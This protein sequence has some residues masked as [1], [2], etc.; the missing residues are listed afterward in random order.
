MHSEVNL[1]AFD[2][3]NSSTKRNSGEPAVLSAVVRK[4]KLKGMKI[5]IVVTFVIVMSL[6]LEATAWCAEPEWV[7]EWKFSECWRHISG[8]MND[9][10][11]YSM[12]IRRGKGESGTGAYS[13]TINVDGYMSKQRIQAKGITEGAKL[14]IE[15][16]KTAADHVGPKHRRGDH[17]LI[18]K[19]E[20][21]KTTTEWN[22]F[23]PELEENIKPGI[24]FQKAKAR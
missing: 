20:D 8:E 11:F 13:V 24:H 6:F 10:V 15:F 18:L 1:S 3:K 22:E 23:Q 9:C 14:T 2:T 7:G 4:R 17:L 5:R 19:S 16:V 21:G 12:S